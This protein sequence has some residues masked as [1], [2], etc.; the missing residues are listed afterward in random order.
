MTAVSLASAVV[1]FVDFSCKIVSKSKQLNAAAR[2]GGMEAN[3]SEI[4]TRDLLKL[5]ENMKEKLSHAVGDESPSEDDQALEE[6]CTRCIGVSE[7][8]LARLEK[9]KVQQGDGKWRLTLQATRSVWSEKELDELSR[10]L[11][12]FRSQLELR[13]LVS[14]RWVF[15]IIHT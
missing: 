6:I 5:S 13:V 15:C 9:L 12:T 11:T 4:V 2:G 10:Q 3:N 7:T 14:F 8:L 1:Q